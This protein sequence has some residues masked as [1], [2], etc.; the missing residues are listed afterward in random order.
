MKRARH[1][2]YRDNDSVEKLLRSCREVC[3]KDMP[4][5][6]NPHDNNSKP[7]DDA[8][9]LCHHLQECKS[10][11]DFLNYLVHKFAEQTTQFRL[12]HE[13]EMLAMHQRL[14]I[15]ERSSTKRPLLL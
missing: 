1:F 14:Q 7:L 15:L 11:I 10:K 12:Q 8:I 5:A 4:S 9:W 3:E 13:Q 2:S 6:R